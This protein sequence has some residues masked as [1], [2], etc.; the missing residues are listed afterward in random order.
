MV[1]DRIQ[2]F[3][4]ASWRAEFP[5]ARSLGF[6]I[7]EWTVDSDRLRENPI[8]T[9]A[10]QDEV[11]ALA[12]EF[13]L[14]VPSLCADCVMEAP[15]YKAGA[16]ERARRLDELTA[17]INACAQTG[18]GVLVIPLVDGGRLQTTAQED[19]L[20]EGLLPLMP[21]LVAAG[22]R[23]A[24]ESDFSPQRL[25]AFIET[26]PS[27]RFGVNYDTGNSASL[28][29]DPREEIEAYGSR[30]WNVHVKDRRRAAGTVPLGAGHADLPTVFRLLS[31]RGYAGNYILQ[32][33]RAPDGNHAGALGRYRDMA[34][35]WLD[36]CRETLS[37]E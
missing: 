14:R 2:A 12:G 20:R 28:G 5:V 25:R 8:M 9:R 7:M 32:T 10:G 18:I 31:A 30:I 26:F 4:W 3:P 1:G 11:R 36:A 35:S 15:F 6:T 21:L 27:T 22:L 13:G 29:Y 23:V 17:L 19:D 24:F 33:A 37:G 16:E 34:V